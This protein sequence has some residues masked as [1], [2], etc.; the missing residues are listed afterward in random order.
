LSIVGFGFS[1][2]GFF[3]AVLSVMSCVIMFCGDVLPISFGSLAV[4]GSVFSES[5]SQSGSVASVHSVLSS[6]SLA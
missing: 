3:L 5:M 6:S 4:F 1:F 2:F